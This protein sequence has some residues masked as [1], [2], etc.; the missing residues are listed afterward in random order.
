V[1]PGSLIEKTL[2]EGVM[3]RT[4]SVAMKKLFPRGTTAEELVRHL[5]FAVLHRDATFYGA[6]Q[7][8]PKQAKAF[9]VDV[10]KILNAA[11]PVEA[12]KASPPNSGSGEKAKNVRKR[13]KAKA[14][15]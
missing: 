6:Y 11:A 2:V 8:F 12:P 3:N 7:H 9:N 4:D 15:K 5:A 1:G 14:S 10:E 13:K